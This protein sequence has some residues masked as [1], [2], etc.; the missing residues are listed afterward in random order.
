MRDSKSELISKNL[1]VVVVTFE[2]EVATRGYIAETGFEWPVLL[3]KNRELYRAYGMLEAGFWDIW[4]LST[5]RAYFRELLRGHLPKKSSGDIRQRGGDVLVDPAGLV[6]LQH[7]GNGPAD[8]PAL[9][10]L[11]RAIS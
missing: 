5:W 11:L 6:R 4:G 1:K 10:T 2:S 3:D 9:D 7:V 8:R